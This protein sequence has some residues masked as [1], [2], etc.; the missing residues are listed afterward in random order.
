MRN[1]KLFL[2]LIALLIGAM[3]FS[4]CGGGGE[5][6]EAPAEAPAQ[7]EAAE[8]PVE[9]EAAEEPVEE[10]AEEPVEEEAE[11]A[12]AETVATLTIWADDKR[13]PVLETLVDDFAELAGV[14]I[15]LEQVQIQDM[16]EQTRVAIPAGE[17]PDIFI[18]A[19]D[20]IGQ[21]VEGGLITPIDLGDKVDNIAPNA[22]Q[23]FNYNSELYA[24]P[25]ATEN[26]GLIR[27]VDL[28]PDPVATLEEMLEVGGPLMEEGAIQ[29]VTVLPSEY[30]THGFHTAFGGY[31]FGLD[32]D[33]NYLPDD[34]G[35]DSPGFIA[36]GEW[37]QQAVNDGYIPT[38]LDYAT[39][40][41]LFA[42]GGMPFI[43][44]GPWAL[45]EYRDAG[46]NFSVD[47]MPNGPDGD[48]APFLGAQGFVVNAQSE[49]QLLAQTFLTELVATDEVMAD[50]QAQDPRIPA[51]LPTLELIDDADL[52]AFGIAGE[53]AQPMP[54]IPQ[55][56]SVWGSWKDGLQLVMNGEDVTETFTNSANQIR[57]AIAGGS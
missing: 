7:E 33:G 53:N 17:G 16:L 38:T 44:N 10:A 50:F 47:P 20:Q 25:Y 31:L 34:I 9:E 21:Y 56:G 18:T 13:I 51:W 1:N 40:N 2:L 36:W 39:A 15:V 24:L 12:P 37:L 48:G 27:N 55:M 54:S 22:L 6:A 41:A 23:A 46:V 8:E 5:D 42:E 43:A 28:V 35:L 4:A 57:D 29:S 11:E 14:E 52:A 3:L 30:A 45:G 26:V 19:H 32:A 49:N